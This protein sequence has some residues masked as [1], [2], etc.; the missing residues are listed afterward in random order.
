VT[1]AY[2]KKIYIYDKGKMVDYTKLTKI[3]AGYT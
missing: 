2:S 3:V 1:K